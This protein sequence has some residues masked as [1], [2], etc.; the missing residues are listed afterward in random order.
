[1]SH[2]FSHLIPVPQPEIDAQF[3]VYQETR[4]FYSEVKLR[5]EHADYCRWYQQISEQHQQEL[6]QMKG[7]LN[8]LQWFYRR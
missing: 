7:E 1:M 2:G 3:Q 8:L 6:A 5:Q 4:A